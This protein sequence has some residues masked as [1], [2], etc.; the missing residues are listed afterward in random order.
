MVCFCGVGVY[1]IPVVLLEWRS[2]YGQAVSVMHNAGV[3]LDKALLY[4]DHITRAVKGFECSIFF[5]SPT[6]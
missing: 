5:H 6:L 4:W 2:K 3:K 1:M